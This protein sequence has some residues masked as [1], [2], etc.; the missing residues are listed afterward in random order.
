MKIVVAMDSFKGRLSA[1][2]A[3]ELVRDGLRQAVPGLEVQLVPMADGGEGTAQAMMTAMRGRWRPATVMGPLPD[4][5][6]E[7]GY[8]WFPEQSL[9]LVEMAAAAGLTLLEPDEQNP[10][11]TTTF[12]VGQLIRQAV[13]QGATA[14]MLTV[15]GSAT[16][17]GGVGAAMALGWRFLD[18]EG[19]PVG[20]GGGALKDIARIEPPSSGGLP[21]P[22]KV[23]CDVTNPLCGE[24][25][26]ATVY[27]PQKGATPEMVRRLEE[28]LSNLAHVVESQLGTSLRYLAGAGAAGGLAA[29]AVAFMNGSLV[30]GIDEVMRVAGLEAA[31]RDAD[32]VITGEG[33][34]DEQSLQGKVVEG[35][36][37]MAAASH[38]RAA[39]LAGC[40]TLDEAAPRPSALR[41]VKAT[42]PSGMTLETAIEK[43]DELLREAAARFARE[44]IMA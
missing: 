21:L 13:D 40:V 6:V 12:G 11:L 9:A 35:I 36:T 32:W 43:G 34:F 17:D 24:L 8:A 18:S 25:G 14:L 33:K 38:T 28:G 2:E 42:M 26:A 19:A 20:Y 10:L 27:G 15:G 1:V 22:V 41:V 5:E 3:C 23:L 30:S 39:V 16:V 31:L 4:R 7:A 44:E 29:G 37:R